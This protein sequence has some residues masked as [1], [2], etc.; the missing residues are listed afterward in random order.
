VRLDPSF[1]RV[2]DLLSAWMLVLLACMHPVDPAWAHDPSDIPAPAEPGLQ[3]SAQLAVGHAWADQSWPRR[4]LPGILGVGSVPTDRRGTALEHGTV[5]A[6]VS[7]AGPWRAAVAAGWHDQDPAHLEL[8]WI[9]RSW[10][11]LRDDSL[12]LGFGRRPVPTGSTWSRAGHFDRFASMPLAKRAVFDG[13]WIDDGVNLRWVHDH[14]G[15]WPW[16][17]Q[18]DV[19]LWRGVATPGGEGDELSPVVHIQ[20]AWGPSTFDVFATRL[21]PAPRAGHVQSAT[22]GHTHSRPRC[23]G[24]LQGVFCF[25]GQSDVVGGTFSTRLPGAL[26]AWW[27]EGAA[28]LRREQG[29]LYSINGDTDYSGTTAG[30]WLDLRWQ[31]QPNWS[32]AGR[33][34]QLRAVQRISG[35]S[36]QV[37]ASDAGITG[38]T[39]LQR[40]ALT[41]G[42]QSP[43]AQWRLSVELGQDVTGNQRDAFQS[44]RLIWAP[45]AF[46]RSF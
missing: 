32:V 7:F 5:S 42:W 40:Q 10:P 23:D 6:G 38:A 9:D 35:R 34:E 37:V 11:V 33:I 24:S 30:Q 28:V 4:T 20:A 44:I 46:T 25:D 26:R 45:P 19:G 12:Q 27:I 36:A 17:Q 13:D 18:M 8:A 39:R 14:G 16:L 22:A 15:W 21:Q 2:C 31:F 43:D 3:L 29:L 1:V 41:L